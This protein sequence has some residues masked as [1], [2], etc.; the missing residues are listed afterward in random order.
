VTPIM[1]RAGMGVFPGIMPSVAQQ[2]IT[3]SKPGYQ[4]D[5]GGGQAER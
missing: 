4:N 5:K 3:Y 2:T 1:M